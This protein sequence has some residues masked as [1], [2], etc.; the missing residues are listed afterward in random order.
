MF[1]LPES[2][3]NS[4]IP[5]YKASPPFMKYEKGYGYM[6]VVLMDTETNK[7]QCHLCGTLVNSMYLHL[8]FKHKKIDG[9]EYRK[10]TGLNKFIPLI[11]E[12]YSKKIRESFTKLPKKEREERIKK[13]CEISRKTFAK[14]RH[15]RQTKGSIQYQNKFSTC[16]LQAKDKFWKEYEALGR[17]PTTNEMSESLKSIIYSR[18]GSYEK[19]LYKWG[20]SEDKINQHLELKQRRAFEARKS[21]RFFPRYDKEVLRKQLL[22]SLNEK[23]ELPTWNELK[24]ELIVSRDTIYRLFGSRIKNEIVKNLYKK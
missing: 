3:S 15:K 18:F 14:G 13:L 8:R 24:R 16:E 12:S 23:G 21:K 22:N 9:K 2:E 17:I 19:A 1:E 5:L 7:I 6:G 11:S 10:I 20:M 4:L